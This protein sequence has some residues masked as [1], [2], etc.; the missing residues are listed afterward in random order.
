MCQN[1]LEILCRLEAHVMH[2]WPILLIKYHFLNVF[3]MYCFQMS[4]CQTRLI[5]I[6]VQWLRLLIV[7]QGARYIW[8]LLS[9]ECAPVS[10][11]ILGSDAGYNVRMFWVLWRLLTH[12][13][14]KTTLSWLRLSPHSHLMVLN[15]NVC[16]EPKTSGKYKHIWKQAGLRQDMVCSDWFVCSRL[17]WGIKAWRQLNQCFLHIVKLYRWF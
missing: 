1:S 13:A 14:D 16:P 7:T 4:I 6:T 17:R 8:W 3:F 9:S 12:C 15:C 5:I 2:K 10:A 11:L